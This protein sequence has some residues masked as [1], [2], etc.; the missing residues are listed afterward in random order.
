[1]LIYNMPR[2]IFLILTGDF[3]KIPLQ[4]LAHAVTLDL[5]VHR[6]VHLAVEIRDVLDLHVRVRIRL[7]RRRRV[8]RRVGVLIHV[9]NPLL[10]EP[11]LLV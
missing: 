3:R 7:R 6:L 8:R 4:P 9:I 1:M 5:P 11:H 10:D 2:Q